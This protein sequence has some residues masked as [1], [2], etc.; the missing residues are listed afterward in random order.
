MHTH[1]TVKKTWGQNSQNFVQLSTLSPTF[2]LMLAILKYQKIHEI[3][4]L[5]AF[6]FRARLRFGLT[7]FLWIAP[8]IDLFSTSILFSLWRSQG[9]CSKSLFNKLFVHIIMLVNMKKFETNSF[10]ANYQLTCIGKIKLTRAK[11]VCYWAHWLSALQL[12][13][14]VTTILNKNSPNWN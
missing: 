7:V 13:T 10:L 5:Q 3:S 4:F 6:V 9:N 11:K 8:S 1:S 2:R 12:E 14:S